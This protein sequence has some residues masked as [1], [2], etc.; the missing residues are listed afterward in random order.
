MSEF[1]TSPDG[2]RIAYDRVGDGPV[3]ILVAGA[4]QFRGFDPATAT[5]ARLLAGKGFAVVNY[6]RRGRGES[7]NA[8]SL[9]LHNEID[10]LSALITANGGEAALFGSSSGGAICLAAATAGLAVTKIALWEVPLGP[11]NGT[12]GAEFLA[13]LRE[14][15]DEGN[16]PGTIEYYMKDMPAEWLEGARNSQAWPVMLELGPS[17]SADAEALAWAQSAPRAQLWSAVS[18][19]TVALVGEQTLP[20]MHSAADSIV[21]NLPNAQKRVIAAADHGWEPIVMAEALAGFLQE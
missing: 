1:I 21:E 17:L 3:V 4:M 7:A 8:T 6:D 19:P 10:D 9:T 16:R 11:E 12:D 13:G 20:V 2:T 15:I 14:R 18:Q 5:M